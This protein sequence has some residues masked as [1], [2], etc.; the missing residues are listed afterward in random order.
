M[1]KIAR[2]KAFVIFMWAYDF[3]ERRHVHIINN[4]SG[5]HNPAKIWLDTLEWM[6]SGELSEQDRAEMERV[7]SKNI[8]KINK[9]I[10]IL[11]TGAKSKPIN[12]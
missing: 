6:D 11:E 4:K 3:A 2:Y 10:D 9:Q 12:L 8:D 5:Y 1:P 7:I